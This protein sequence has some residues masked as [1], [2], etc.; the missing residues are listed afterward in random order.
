MHL[1]HKQTPSLKPVASLHE[2]QGLQCCTC[3]LCCRCNCDETTLGLWKD[4][5]F[6]GW[7]FSP[8]MSWSIW[9]R[10]MWRIKLQ[11]LQ[12]NANNNLLM[13]WC[14]IYIIQSWWLLD[15]VWPSSGLHLQC[16]FQTALHEQ[17][18]ALWNPHTV[19]II[20]LPFGGRGGGI[21]HRIK[22]K[23]NFNSQQFHFYTSKCMVYFIIHH[24][25]MK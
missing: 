23:K 20:F 24:T 16:F 12:K 21:L 10:R 5:W 25:A 1:E 19:W 6:P 11:H 14:V 7:D 9:H 2:A 8:M 22:K 13:L 4:H 18:G 3:N 15:F 17:G